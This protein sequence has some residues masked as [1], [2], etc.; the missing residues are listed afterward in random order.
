MPYGTC[1]LCCTTHNP[2]TDDNRMDLYVPD[3]VDNKGVYT[4][5]LYD[6]QGGKAS[7]M[8]VWWQ[9]VMEKSQYSM[10]PVD[11]I[12]FQASATPWAQHRGRGSTPRSACLSSG[13]PR[14]R[15][16]RDS[17]GIRSIYGTLTCGIHAHAG[18]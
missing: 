16:Q 11:N 5:T 9:N 7:A 1:T 10:G 12:S 15:W 4:R 8:V 6:G 14:M 3:G 17:G 13:A 18:R 2:P